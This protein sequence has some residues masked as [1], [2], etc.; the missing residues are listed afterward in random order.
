MKLTFPSGE[1]METSAVD[2]V[3]FVQDKALPILNLAPLIYAPSFILRLHRG[4][5]LL[6][7]KFDSL[8]DAEHIAKSVIK[9]ME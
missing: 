1:E 4:A 9:F 2:R 7:L 5:K 8:Q 6:E 3:E